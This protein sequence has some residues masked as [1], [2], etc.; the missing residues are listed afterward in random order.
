MRFD[1]PAL[2]QRGRMDTRLPGRFVPLPENRSALLAMQQLADSIHSRQLSGCASPLFVHGPTGT[3]KTHLV[4]ALVE[5]LIRQT[6]DIVIALHSARDMEPASTIDCDLLVCEDVQHLPE[7]SAETLVQWF[8][9]LLAHRLPM[10][11]TSTLGPRQLAHVPAR[12]TSR[13][14]CGLVVGI[15]RL[16]AASRLTLLRELAQRRQLAVAPEVLSWL[17][18]HLTGG[19]RE[20]DGA[21]ARLELLMRGPGRTLDLATVANYFRE[22]VEAARPTAER[23][24]ER[25]STY[26]HVES[27]CLRSPLRSW[28]VLL[29]RQVGMYLARQLTGLSLEQ[30][31]DYFGGRDHSTVLHACRKVEQAL[32][33]DSSLAGAVRQLQMEL[34]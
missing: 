34:A 7:R 30:I 18:E 15:D 9:H 6:P 27:S 5:E 24:A 22:Q 28:K 16:S 20:L 21:L 13:L 19:A 14:A 3:G 26:F 10:V 29:P 12:L 17:A 8:D 23:I 11:F 1:L 25:V 32:S 4:A 31:G 2:S 33:H